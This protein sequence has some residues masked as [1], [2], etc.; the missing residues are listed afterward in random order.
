MTIEELRRQRHDKAKQAREILNKVEAEKRDMTR[1]ERDTFDASSRRR[2]ASM[3][4]ED[5]M[6]VAEIPDPSRFPIPAGHPR[7]QR[8]ARSRVGDVPHLD[9]LTSFPRV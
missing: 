5:L 9:R 1:E 6:G 3:P 7:I 4:G 2:R 8:L